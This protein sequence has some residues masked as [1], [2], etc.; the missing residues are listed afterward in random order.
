MDLDTDIN[1]DFEEN[2]PFQEDVI[3]ETYQRPDRLYFQEPP[4][5]DSLNNMG[6]LVQKFLLNQAIIGKILKI[7]QRKVLKGT[8]LPVAVKEIQVS[9]LFSPYFK[10]LY[11]CLAPN[12]LYRTKT[13]IHKVK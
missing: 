4:E 9:Y 10:D 5:S 7:I 1:T 13:E 12:K 8:N 11:L 6:R 2:S 3:S